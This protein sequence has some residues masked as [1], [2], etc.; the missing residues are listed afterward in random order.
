[1]YNITDILRE[2]K[3]GENDRE[4]STVQKYRKKKLTLQ[5]LKNQRTQKKI[6]P[7]KGS[8][9]VEVEKKKLKK[10][11]MFVVVFVWLFFS[12]L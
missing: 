7:K 11:R 6:E 5:L 3:E 8:I 12:F 10:K 1:M 4:S 9:S 2:R